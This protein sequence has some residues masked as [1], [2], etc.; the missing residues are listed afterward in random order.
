MKAGVDKQTTTGMVL[1]CFDPVSNYEMIFTKTKR[2]N[3][4]WD[5]EFMDVLRGFSTITVIYGHEYFLRMATISNIDTE[6]PT[7]FDSPTFVF[8]Y[9]CLYS[10]DIF[11]FLSGFFLSFATIPRLQKNNH[12]LTFLKTLFNRYLRLIPLY[13]FM[14]CC[15]W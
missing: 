15:Y 1:E 11:F 7:F 13:F 12:P 9:F 10:V 6:L 3:P 5:L 2:R 4:K 8:L 14:I